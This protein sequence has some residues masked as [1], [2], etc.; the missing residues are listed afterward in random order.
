MLARAGVAR[1]VTP[2]SREDLRGWHYVLTGGVLGGLSPYGFNQGMTG[3]WAYVND[4][5]ANCAAALRRLKLILDAAG[6]APESVS[7]LPDRASQI[8]GAA[9][10]AMF[11]L[12]VTDFDPGI[13]AAHRLVVAYDLTDTDQDAVTALR[14]RAP[15]QILFERAMRWT[16]PPR[17]TADVTGL[18]GQMV[19]PPWAPQLRQL[20]DGSVGDGPADDRPAEAVADEIV[21]AT[22]AQDE[23]DGEAPPDLDEDLQRFVAAITTPAARDRDGGW[24]GGMREYIRDA[25][26][27]PSSRFL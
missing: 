22:P 10:A 20:E 17:V 1:A 15:G 25:G 16:A 9:A 24:L 13:P 21:H 8:V 11:G 3:R 27:V 7:P 6:A 23:G 18:L 26:P 12:P 14:Q 5:T 4:S 19:V 2:L